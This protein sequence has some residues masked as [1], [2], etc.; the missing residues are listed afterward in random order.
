MVRG[1]RQRP[2]P[3]APGIGQARRHHPALHS[4]S[5]LPH[6]SKPGAGR[7]NL[8]G[9]ATHRAH[10]DASDRTRSAAGLGR[11]AQAARKLTAN[12]E[13]FRRPRFTAACA[14]V[15]NG[16][17]FAEVGL[18][19][20]PSEK[21]TQGEPARRRQRPL[22]RPQARADRRNSAGLS[23]PSLGMH[24][25]DRLPAGGNG[26]RTVG[27]PK[28]DIKMGDGVGHF[29]PA[30][31]PHPGPDGARGRRGKAHN[32]RKGRDRSISL[33]P[34]A[35]TPWESAAPAGRPRAFCGAPAPLG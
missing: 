17:S 27:P 6:L 20:C 25:R 21:K 1:A 24:Y 34:P 26:I 10:C 12:P 7:G 22:S 5:R 35:A 15:A 31:S 18:H 23:A 33:S 30:R 19:Q 8:A 32:G 2:R 11:A 9:P 13:I 4:A 16:L 3:I 29:T 28:N 14:V